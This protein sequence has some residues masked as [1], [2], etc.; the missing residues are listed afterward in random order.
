MDNHSDIRFVVIG[1]GMAGI[2][3]GIKLLE[4][5]FSNICIYEK[6]DK[7]G[8]TWR[9]NT[10]PGLTCDVP[11]HAY[12]YAFEPNPDWSQY[13][14]EG[15]EI[16]Q[17][18]ERTVAKYGVGKLIKFN[19]EVSRC[20]FVDGRWQIETHRGTRDEADVVIAATGVLHAPNYP[21]IKGAKSFKG[22]MFHS[23]RWDHG[24]PL[25]GKRIGVIGTGSTGVQIVS[26]LSTRAEKLTHFQRSAQWIMPVENP[27]YS[28]EQK[29]AFRQ[30]AALLKHMQD[31]PAYLEAVDRFN[32]AIANPES[33]AMHEIEAIVLQNLEDNVADLEL[34]EKLRPNYRAA[35][36]RL[37]YSPDYYQAIQHPNVSLVDDG[38]ECIEPDGV[39]TRDGKL[40][41]FEVLVLATGFQAHRF[42]RPME[43]IGRGGKTLDE[44]WHK[45][46]TAYMSISI[47]EFPNFF[48]LNG[49]NGPVG[50]FSLIEIAEHQWQYISQLIRLVH[51]GRY[52]E[53]SA[54][55]QA[56]D[57]FDRERVAAARQT[58]FGSGCQSW[59]LDADGVPATWPWDRQRFFDEM[60]A[61]RLDAFDLVA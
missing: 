25:D 12:T 6:A 16:Y 51:S 59:Y 14:A 47:P 28:E 19:E 22:A 49:P 27:A 1:S 45:G 50:N 29:E 53:V 23:A 58:I 2:L 15:G 52:R 17:Y 33:D 20:E 40:H 32:R 24:V 5:G 43:I 46:P 39:R 35:C 57:I 61:P 8:G 21:D 26:A 30:D 11:A 3:S 55:Q 9:E 48:M 7:V 36:K 42:M 41:A 4:A 31:E 10:Y 37:V 56:L 13:L 44:A 54:S 18:F 38:I 34:R 60:V